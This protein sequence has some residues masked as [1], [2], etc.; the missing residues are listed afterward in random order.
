MKSRS[1]A[2]F[3]GLKFQYISSFQNFSNLSIPFTWFFMEYPVYDHKLA[4]VGNTVFDLYPVC[5]MLYVVGSQW[6]II[7]IVEASFVLKTSK[8]YYRALNAR[9][10]RTFLVQKRRAICLVNPFLVLVYL[11]RV[12]DLLCANTKK[13]CVCDYSDW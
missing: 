6:T 2:K 12:R 5:I 4:K 3:I 13:K 1:L 10:R 8:V 9:R 7:R 11:K